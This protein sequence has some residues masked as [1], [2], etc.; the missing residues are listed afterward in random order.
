ML[1]RESFLVQEKKTWAKAE[2]P[3]PMHLMAL[4]FKGRGQ[5]WREEDRELPGDAVGRKAEGKEGVS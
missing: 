4:Y 1:F 2:L 3:S 5:W